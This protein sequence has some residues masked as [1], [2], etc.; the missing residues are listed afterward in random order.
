MENVFSP[1][2]KLFYNDYNVYNDFSPYLQGITYND[3]LEDECDEL[4]IQLRDDDKL[5]QNHWYPQK[6][7]KLKCSISDGEEVLNC[8]TF[9]IDSINY[10]FD[11]NG[12]TLNIRAIAATT[13]LPL[14][15]HRSD[16][17]EKTT[18]PMIAKK[19]ADRHGLEFFTNEIFS[20]DFLT[21][22]RITQTEESDLGFLRRLSKEYGYVF[23][24][25]DNLLSFI[26]IYDKGS[27][28]SLDKSWFASLNFDDTSVK[29]YKGGQ[30]NYYN[31]EKKSLQTVNIGD[32]SGDILKMRKKFTSHAQGLEIINSQIKNL[33]KEL[34][35]TV[36]LKRPLGNFISG[37]N[38][39]IK[40]F[41]VFDGKYEIK[42]TTHKITDSYW[43]V[44]GEI[45]RIENLNPLNLF[46]K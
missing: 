41:G 12:N 46:N 7:A 25:T 2:I 39:N 24:L 28:F 18:V 34:K 42:K 32:T 40:G 20:N 44:K 23:K 22:D 31:P 21:V 26:K 17:Y 3:F 4:I 37:V 16:Y 9:T 36:A 33:S 29:K 27:V 43:S 6:G 8:G 13:L 10:Q 35:G 45:E 1:K 11:E 14:R 30:I 19:I 5:F 15:T 38:F